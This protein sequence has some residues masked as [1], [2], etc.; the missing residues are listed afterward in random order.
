MH[1]AKATFTNGTITI[2]AEL[3]FN[4]N[5]ELVNFISYDR[6]ETNGNTYHNFPWS[7]PV[8]DYKMLNG[9]LLPSQGSMIYHKS[10]GEFTYGELTYKS[11]TYNVTE[12]QDWVF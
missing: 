5:H 9:Y 12:M 6:Y 1:I 4:K 8:K 11:V 7:T 10:E 3:Y 2:S